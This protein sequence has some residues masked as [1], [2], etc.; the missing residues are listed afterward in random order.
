MKT[1]KRLLIGLLTCAAFACE[2]SYGQ[3]RD[4]KKTKPLLANV[5]ELKSVPDGHFLVNLELGGEERVL[6]FEVRDNMAKCVKASEARLKGL[7]G[8]FQL[9][10][11]GVFQIFLQGE[12]FRAS[13]IWIFRKDGSAAIREVP[14]RGEQQNALPV[15]NESLERPKGTR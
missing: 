11:N 1:T 9:I 4:A 14:D 10:Q 8:K 7:Q 6:N 15:D 3:S 12:N 2:I 5:L 13:Q